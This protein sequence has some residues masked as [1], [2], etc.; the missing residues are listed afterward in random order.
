MEGGEGGRGPNNLWR[1]SA[2]IFLINFNGEK[3]TAYP[4][5]V[6]DFIYFG[7]I[8]NQDPGAG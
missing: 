8:W 6:V 5:A 1:I 2:V 7:E 3:S 4:T